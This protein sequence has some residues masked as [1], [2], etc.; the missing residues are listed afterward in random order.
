[1]KQH[2]FQTIILHISPRF[3][4]NNY[5]SVSPRFPCP[6]N[7]LLQFRFLYRFLSPLPVLLMLDFLLPLP[8]F[9]PTCLV[10]I[11]LPFILLKYNFCPL[12]IKSCTLSSIPKQ[13]NLHVIQN[14][15]KQANFPKIIHL[16]QSQRDYS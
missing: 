11:Q 4:I 14:Q 3:L 2:N 15:N 8:V 10:I 13:I 16:A 5:Q 6:P 7:F 9:Q 12:N 1:M